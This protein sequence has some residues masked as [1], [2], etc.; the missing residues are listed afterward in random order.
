MIDLPDCLCGAAP[1]LAIS[2][3]TVRINHEQDCLIRF[4]I[5]MD[6]GEWRELVSLLLDRPALDWCRETQSTIH[7]G[8]GG[9]SVVDRDGVK[10]KDGVAYKDGKHIEPI[11]GIQT[12]P[13]LYE[14][15]QKAQL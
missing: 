15:V 1:D 3:G 13:T 2:E 12:A 7:F 9:V 6:H 5:I 11:S 10:Y 14:A 4:A 8:N